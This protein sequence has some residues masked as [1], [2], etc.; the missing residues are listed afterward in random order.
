MLAAQPYK[1]A[2]QEQ[3]SSNAAFFGLMIAVMYI[4]IRFSMI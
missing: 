4:D 3:Q 2:K 1:N